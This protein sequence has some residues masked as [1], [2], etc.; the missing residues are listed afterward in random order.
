MEAANTILILL[1]ENPLPRKN[2]GELRV[3][4]E[5]KHMHVSILV[6]LCVLTPGIEK[7]RTDTFGKP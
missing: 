3:A 2:N 5:I 7:L 6:A 4:C 1:M